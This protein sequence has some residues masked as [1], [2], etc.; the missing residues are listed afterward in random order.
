MTPERWQKIKALLQEALERD[1]LERE[2]FLD[3]ACAG[4]SAMRVEVEALLD[5]LARSGDFIESPA[6]QVLAD[7][8]TETDLAPGTAIGPYEIIR[9]LGSGGMGD[10]YL[11]QDMRL[12]RKVALKA[13]PAHFMKDPERVR[14]FQLE[15]KA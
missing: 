6:Y 14:R 13:L 12:G 1:P 15:A 2:A 5:S 10:I 9:R 7:S 3:E 8:L 4:D 11:A